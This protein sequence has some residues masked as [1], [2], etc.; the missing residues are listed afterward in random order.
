MTGILWG[1]QGMRRR[2]SVLDYSVQKRKGQLGQGTG[3]LVPDL[4]VGLSV[5]LISLPHESDLVSSS[6]IYSSVYSM[7][8]Y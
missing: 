8:I 1:C 6:A 7:N 3:S 4:G 2:G 5:T